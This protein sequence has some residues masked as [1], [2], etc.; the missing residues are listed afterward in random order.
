MGM[1]SLTVYPINWFRIIIDLEKAGLSDLEIAQ[2]VGCAKS[3]ISDLKGDREP[4][5]TL[6]EKLRTLHQIHCLSVQPMR[7]VTP[8]AFSSVL[9][10]T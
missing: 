9:P 4:L 7:H 2:K 5:H 10:S 8:S 3:A 1:P 6:G